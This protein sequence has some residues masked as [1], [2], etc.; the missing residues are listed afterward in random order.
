MITVLGSLNMDLVTTVKKTPLVGETIL[1]SGLD[2]IPGGKGANQ[3]VTIGKLGGNIKMIGKIGNDE[4]GKILL[5]SLS[6][7]S[8]NIENIYKSDLSTGLAFIMVNRNGDNSIVVIPGANFDINEEE[9][10]EKKHIIESSNIFVTQLETPLKVVAK[11]LKIAKDARIRTILN[12][13]PA[14]ELSDSIIS[15][16]D[17]LTPNKSELEILSKV[18]ITDDKSLMEASNIMISKGVK[19]L[20]VTLGENGSLL[21]NSEGYEKFNAVKVNAVDTTAAG[22]SFTGA[23]AYELDRG[24]TIRKAI[25]IATNVAALSVTRKGAQTALPSRNELNEFMK[26]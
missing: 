9:I 15:T 1:G 19:N 5:E 2:Y 4:Y 8:V 20:I 6:K 7:S 17:I 18:K 26:G 16:V 12:P 10:I 22:D 23:I 14:K 21:V 25:K 13:A 3:A 24:S 11:G